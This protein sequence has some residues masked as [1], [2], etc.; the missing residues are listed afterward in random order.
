MGSP[1]VCAAC[2]TENPTGARF[3]NSCGAVLTAAAAERRKLVTSV[4]CDLNGSTAIAE[5]VDAESV[6]ELMRTYYDTARAAL[7]RHGGTVE[8][9]IGDAVVGMFGVPEAHEDD[10]LRACRA[11]LE[12]QQAIAAQELALEIRIGVN[13]GEVVAGDGARRE[14]FASGNAVVLGDSVNVAARLEQA[15]APGEILIGDATYR[16]VRDAVSVEP[17][18]PVEAKGKSEP[19]EAHRLL[20]ARTHG[21]VRRWADTALVG[22]VAELAELEACLVDDGV[23]LVTV[24]GEAGVGK[25]RLV[26]ELAARGAER[27]RIVRGACLSYGESITFWP[28]AQIIRELAGIRDDHSAEEA[29]ARLSPRLAQL[30]GLSEGAATA[31]Q[32]VEEV[33]A[34]LASAADER[35]LVVL[36]DDI[37]WAEPAL[38]DLLG[39]L[40]ARVEGSPITVLCLARPELLELRPD[41]PVTVRLDPLAAA[42]VDTLL[43]S[44]EAPAAARVRLAQAA[45]GNPLFVEE[46]VAWVLDGGDVDALP[47]SLNALLGS[48]LDRLEAPARDALERAAVEGELFHE[49]TV[50]ELSEEPSRRAVPGELGELARKDFIRLAAASLVAG[51]IAYRFKHILVREAAYRATT[52]KL[53]ASSTNAS[54]TGSS[55]APET[56]SASITRSSATTSSRPAGIGR[57]SA[58]RSLRSPRAP[59]TTSEPPVDAPTIVATCGVPPNLL[60]RATALLLPDSLERLTLM[61]PWSYAVGESGR[62]PE[63]YSIGEELY[64]RAAALGDRGLA[65]HARLRLA[66]LGPGREPGADLD[67]ARTTC[68]EVIDTFTE[69]GDEMGLAR[70]VRITGLLCAF[71]GRTAEQEQWLERALVHADACGDLPTRRLV[72]QSLAMSLVWG[73]T[74]AERALHRCE[75]LRAR[76]QEDRLLAAVIVRCLSTLQ[77]M[78]GRYDEARALYSAAGRVLDDARLDSSSWISRSLSAHTLELIG[79]RPGAERELNERWAYFRGSLGGAPH[80]NAIESAYD[81]A[82]LYCD[83][84]RWDEAEACATFYRD[85]PVPLRVRPHATA[86]G[87][88]AEARVAAHRGEL[89]RASALAARALELAERTD[90]L[91]VLPRAWLAIADVEQASG[92]DDRADAAASR[93]LELYERKGNLAAAARLQA[94]GIGA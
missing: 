6:F 67:A 48:R 84:G 38:L 56:V 70:A 75:E 54:P 7:E 18:S 30:V 37:H 49:G 4:F 16:L 33:A 60:G 51:E 19:L 15:A 64:E 34:L 26:A 85:V 3:C 62:T 74:P 17:V 87:L 12:I 57:S 20:A 73:P 72:T 28:V 22:R 88:A 78:A 11:A 9:F 40:P 86:C 21:A 61:V 93:A 47:T 50:V 27:A 79:D 32:A 52:K 77:A 31:D 71:E 44:L 63:A 46:L 41:W 65:A 45:A 76:S 35:P 24:V 8:K 89:G 23:R 5:T 13:T 58:I 55:G 82:L 1:A 66:G 10:A 94:V 29:R 68:L 42:E 36:V 69:L 81:L 80:V 39:A 92:R 90:R 14:M 2:G 25:S 59:A 83:D 43:E 53:R 91:D